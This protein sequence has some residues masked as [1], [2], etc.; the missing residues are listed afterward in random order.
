MKRLTL[1]LFLVLSAVSLA[2]GQIWTAPPDVSGMY[3]VYGPGGQ[4]WIRESYPLPDNPMVAGNPTWITTLTPFGGYGGYGPTEK[5]W[6]T[7]P[8]VAG[9]YNTYGPHGQ[10]WG[11]SPN[12]AGGYSGYGPNGQPWVNWQNSSVHA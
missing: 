1:S 2:E 12:A 3:R 4:V 9:G 6:V 10:A 11:S 8:N 7:E 5:T